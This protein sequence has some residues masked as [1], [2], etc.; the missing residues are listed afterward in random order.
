MTRLR[1]GPGLLAVGTTTTSVAPGFVIF[2]AW[3]FLLP[4]S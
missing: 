1:A 4:A 3:A 2:E